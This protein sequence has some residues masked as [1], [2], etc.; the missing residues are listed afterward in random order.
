MT[1]T[2]GPIAPSD[3]LLSVRDLRV[4]FRAHGQEVAAVDGANFDVHRGRTLG[5]VGESGS[6]KSVT[7]LSLLG[8][9]PKPPACTVRGSAYFNSLDLLA[10]PGRILQTLRGNRISFIFQDPL[11]ALNPYLTIGA[12]LIEP[13][14]VHG[15]AS[16]RAARDQ[17][18]AALA[19]VGIRDPQGRFHDYPHEFSGGMRQRAMIA[20]ALITQ[21]DLLIADEPTTALDMTTQAQILE[22]LLELKQRRGMAMVFV[23]HDLRVV[24]RIA[25]DVVV[26]Q[27]GRC[28]ETGPAPDVL[29]APQAD[30][31]RRLVDAVPRGEKRRAPDRVLRDP[32]PLLCVE[33]LGITYPARAGWMSRPIASA[34]ALCNVTLDVYRGEILGVVGESGSGKS[35]L[36]RTLI[37]LLDP[38]R[39]T[40][41][42]GLLPWSDLK[43][44]ALRANRAR[45]QMIFQDPFSSLN[46]RMTVHDCLAEALT[47]RRSISEPGLRQRVTE[48]LN[49][50][51][52]D[53][54]SATRY[55]HEFSGGQRQR[56]AIARALAPEPELLIADEPVSALDVT[57]QAEILRLLLDLNHRRRLS[58]LFISHDLSV[59]R[60]LADRVAV[61]HHG[62]IVELAE[63]DT[64]F[65]AP[66]HDCT[67]AL[68]AALP[69]FDFPAGVPE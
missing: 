23:S 6:G 45:M 3:S 20:M 40:V 53:P 55:P 13:L 19:E 63:T 7:C 38:G 49:D 43:P 46:P 60:Y 11:A 57:V 2:P 58:M 50:V 9:L 29:A 65:A 27:A 36:A 69:N 31:T 24:S 56:I 44:A 18:V 14:R 41:A 16:A 66:Q 26:M 25:D 68:L 34:P 15:G 67:R 61:M 28:V 52:L 21:P 1:G 35:T 8:L 51:E 39:G 37:R 22:L 64:L 10:Q 5:I 17:A 32:G 54:G 33:D 12:Q 4:S 47:V 59:I 42:L 30:Y 48:L 62:R